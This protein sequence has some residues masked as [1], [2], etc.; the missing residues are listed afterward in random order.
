MKKPVFG[1]VLGGVLGVFDG[2]VGDASRRR[3]CGRQIIGIV[4][5]STFKGSSRDSSSDTSPHGHGS[6][7]I[8]L[9]AGLVVGPRARL[10]GDAR[11]AVLLGDH[12]A[13]R[14]RRPDRRLRDVRLRRAAPPHDR[15]RNP[16]SRSRC[17]DR[18]GPRPGE[19]DRP[20]RHVQARPASP[21]SRR[22]RRDARTI[23]RRSRGH[24]QE[25]EQRIGQRRPVQITS[26]SRRRGASSVDRGPDD[27][28]HRRS[29]AIRP[30]P[31][32]PRRVRR[33][34]SAAHH[35]GAAT[36]I[37]RARRA[38]PAARRRPRTPGRPRSVTI[39]QRFGALGVEP[40][41]GQHRPALLVLGER[42]RRV[43]VSLAPE[44]RVLDGHQRLG[45]AEV[46]VSTRWSPSR[47]TEW[48][49][50]RTA[51]RAQDTV[52]RAQIAVVALVAPQHLWSDGRRDGFGGGSTS[53][54]R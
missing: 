48:P 49:S 35:D 8:G 7:P 1:M 22:R 16:V 42:Q 46:G 26:R 21:A 43:A 41:P 31:T 34:S 20:A 38:A 36:P 30:P 18:S 10:P 53:R 51:H 23:P 3:R 27:R 54:F 50:R 13:R 37:A 29:P 14:H 24:R 25:R 9:A 40:W 6:L 5:G 17:A 2:L 15:R 45:A 39:G 28:P 11:R 19:E 4:L 52:A 33:T 44:E 47:R 32:T 12:A